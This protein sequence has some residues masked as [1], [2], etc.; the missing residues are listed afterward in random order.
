MLVTIKDTTGIR[1]EIESVVKLLAEYVMLNSAVTDSTSLYYGRA[2]M[3]LCLFNVARYL[4]DVYVED[5]AFNLLKQSLLNEK[6]DIRFDRG[7]SGIGYALN[8]AIRNKF[9]EADFCDIFKKQHET[10][11]EEFL[12]KDYD[13]LDLEYVISLWHIMLYFFYIQDNRVQR[14]KEELCEKCISWFK[15]I[16]RSIEEATTPIDKEVVM[17]Q[18][19]NYLKILSVIGGIDNYEHIEGYLK[20][21]QRGLLKK[22]VQALYYISN[23]VKRNNTVSLSTELNS[24]LGSE[25]TFIYST[26]D[27]L[28]AKNLYRQPYISYG[29]IQNSLRNSFSLKDTH[30]I[31]ECLKSKIIQSSY[32][33]SLSFG[34]SRIV[35]ALLSL[36]NPNR[37]EIEEIIYVI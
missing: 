22:D 16:W 23:I 6:R 30:E 14:K 28:N 21:L 27:L 17:E 36:Y 31:E 2:G 29:I 26:V 7:L 34:I 18:W 3:S 13:D 32:S 11:V 19:R 24:L 25:K 5:F 15:M 9:V 12:K 8:Y 4:D 20:L 1:M 37:P 10:I 33:S 35:V